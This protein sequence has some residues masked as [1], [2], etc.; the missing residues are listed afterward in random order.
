MRLMIVFSLIAFLTDQVS[1]YWVVHVMEIWRHHE[2]LPV[3]P[4][5]LNFSYGENR[6][7][8]FGLFAS[9][10]DVMRWGLSGLAV[11]I[12]LA[13][14]IWLRRQPQPGIVHAFAGLLIGGALG[15]VVDRVWYGFVLDFLNSSCCGWV[16]PTVYN[17]ADV[18]IVVG[19]LGLIF[20]ARDGKDGPKARTGKDRKKGA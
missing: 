17:V 6:G 8:N 19:A 16:N 11:V 18:F 10:S 20:F 5:V 14:V 1:K 4:P 13:V 2:M 7:I 3:I 9:D 15:N 12:C